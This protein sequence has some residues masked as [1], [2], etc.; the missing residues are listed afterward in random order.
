MATRLVGA[1][2]TVSFRRT[3]DAGYPAAT[4]SSP[5]VH[6]RSPGSV[7][8]QL[9]CQCVQAP[10]R[11]FRDIPQV[12]DVLG[13]NPRTTRRNVGARAP[14]PP[15]MTCV[16]PTRTR[17]DGIDLAHV[18]SGGGL[19]AAAGNDERDLR[20]GRQRWDVE[21]ALAA[22][23]LDHDPRAG[24]GLRSGVGDVHRARLH[25]ELECFATT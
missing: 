21:D 9:A 14:K 8:E 3:A 15:A 25:A 6:C 24:D 11:R 7:T 13:G 16:A 18:D 23:A 22:V 12:R 5:H 10:E 1:L 17:S 20:A 2:S 4:T 19:R